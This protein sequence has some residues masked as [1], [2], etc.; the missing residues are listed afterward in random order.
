V[1]ESPR[2]SIVIPA[3]N[4]GDF[5]ADT[6]AS[7]LAQTFTSYE[8]ILV[9]DGSPDT[10]KLENAIAPF[11]QNIIYIK[12]KNAGAAVAR[13]T[14]IESASGEIL[15]FLDGDDVWLPEYLAAQIECLEKNKYEMA[16]ADAAFFGDSYYKQET[17]MQQTPSTGEVTPESLLSG[18]CN[19]I[20]SGTVCLRKVI[21]ENGFFDPNSDRAED[22]DMWFRLAKNGVRI[23]YQQKVLLKYR[24]RLSGLTGS[25]LKRTERTIKALEL[26]R[27]KNTLSERELQVWRSRVDLSLAELELEKGKS[28]LVEGKYAQA[29]R[30]FQTANEYQQKLKLDA[31]I[32]MLGIYPKLVLKLFKKFRA[33]ET[34]FIETI[35]THDKNQ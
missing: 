15:A 34:S 5:I 26:V 31:I 28:C 21:V 10:E 13:N 18:N 20:T 32:L 12:Q 3:Y 22:F 25:N 14:A 9:N 8:I 2:V 4:V 23:G 6:L 17:F 29:R 19:V 1:I 35:D 27:A 11:L 33:G 16:Y 30:H 7:V 24:V